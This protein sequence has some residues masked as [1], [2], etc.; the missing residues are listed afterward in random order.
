MNPN[1]AATTQTGPRNMAL[2]R[3]AASAVI[4]R[5]LTRASTSRA[6]INSSPG[7]I[8]D[9]GQRWRSPS[10]MRI[11]WPNTWPAMPSAIA[12]GTGSCAGRT[13]QS[14]CA[15]TAATARALL[16]THMFSPG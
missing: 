13:W 6:S 14:G 9:R 5:A 7:T 10:F 4:N 16:A 3:P 2:Y 8:A 11:N 12:L 1:N 15:S